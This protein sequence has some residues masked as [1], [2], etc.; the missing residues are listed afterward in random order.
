V[1]IDCHIGNL[2]EGLIRLEVVQNLAQRHHHSV[3]TVER[4][5]QHS[6]QS[7]DQWSRSSL[8]SKGA[9]VMAL[10]GAG[11]SGMLGLTGIAYADEAEHG[12]QAPMYPWVH[13]GWFSSYDHASSVPFTLPLFFWKLL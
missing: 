1:L 8:G 12:L 5:M 2:R 10:I 6:H 7:G 13:D 9:R 11:V 4:H 3:F